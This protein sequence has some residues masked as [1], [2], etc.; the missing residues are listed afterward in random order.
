M[1]ESEQTKRLYRKAFP[2]NPDAYVEPYWIELRELSR[3]LDA[4]ER[5]EA[6]S[7]PPLA[8][9]SGG[10]EYRAVPVR[11]RHI[12]VRSHDMSEREMDASWLVWSNEH[13][14]WWGP[15]HRGYFTDVASAGRYTLKEANDICVRAGTVN[16]TRHDPE[17][18]AEVVVPSPEWIAAALSAQGGK[19]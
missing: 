3:R 14:A 13:E 19:A 15:N 12:Q 18:P 6:L 9:A 5:H 7:V 10:G 11:R 2:I 1:S 17:I 8:G 4:I 16:R